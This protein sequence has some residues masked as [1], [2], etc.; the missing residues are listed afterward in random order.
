MKIDP[1]E[2]SDRLHGEKAV[3]RIQQREDQSGQNWIQ[4]MPHLSPVV[5]GA[6]SSIQRNPAF[7]FLKINVSSP[8]DGE[9]QK[10]LGLM[11]SDEGRFC[12][13]RSTDGRQ[14][15]ICKTCSACRMQIALRQNFR[16]QAEVG[17]GW[18]WGDSTNFG[19]SSPQIMWNVSFRFRSLDG[20]LLLSSSFFEG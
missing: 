13:S 16:V 15:F 7:V 10:D 3:R 5:L 8:Q 12:C 2:P 4:G 19:C 20:F 18:G 9:A 6:E 14:C 11:E 1:F 17:W